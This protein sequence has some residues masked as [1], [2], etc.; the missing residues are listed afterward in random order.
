VAQTM[1]I[2]DNK[3]NARSEYERK[4]F[5]RYYQV[6]VKYSGGQK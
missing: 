5:N 4:Y 3:E 1:D 2:S 6:R